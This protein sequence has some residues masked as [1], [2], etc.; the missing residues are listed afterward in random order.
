MKL[1]L[2]LAQ[3]TEIVKTVQK[4]ATADIS[5]GDVV[6]F[7]GGYH[8]VSS[9]ASQPT[10]SARKAGPAKC[11]NIAKGAAHPYHLI[12][13]AYTSVGGDSNVYGWVDASTV[14]KS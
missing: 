4:Q 12:G 7:A 5:V 10:G 2:A 6:Q 11:T 13:G 9:T 3:D 14:S 8:Y 1:K